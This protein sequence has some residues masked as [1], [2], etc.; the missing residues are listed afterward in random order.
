MS[1]SLG[2]QCL[3][4]T[5]HTLGAQCLNATWPNLGGQCLNATWRL[6]N[7][8]YVLP[9]NHG[10]NSY[11]NDHHTKPLIIHLLHGHP[12]KPRMFFE[13]NH[14]ITYFVGFYPIGDEPLL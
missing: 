9:I 3:N 8:N 11:P 13:P 1:F 6:N 5:W 14:P 7:Q 12:K 2:G 10:L 4:A